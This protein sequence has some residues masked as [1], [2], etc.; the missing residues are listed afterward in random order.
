MSRAGDWI[1]GTSAGEDDC[2]VRLADLDF[3]ERTGFPD[4]HQGALVR[5]G[6]GGIRQETN[7]GG[8]AGATVAILGGGT[9]GQSVLITCRAAGAGA[10]SWP[11]PRP[12]DAAPAP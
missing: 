1:P 2:L 6:L 3:A 7:T 12:W 4:Q 9:I 8:L 10:V 11:A 5:I